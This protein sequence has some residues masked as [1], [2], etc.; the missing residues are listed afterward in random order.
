MPKLISEDG[1]DLLKGILTV[2]PE[3]RLTL[4][5]IKHHK[6]FSVSEEK[7]SE[8]II[9]GIHQI[10]VENAII[11]RLKEF[12]ID[13]EYTKK[14]IEANKHNLSTTTY[15][16]LLQKYIREGGKTSAN[17]SSKLFSPMLIGRNFQNSNDSMN[18][19]A[20]K[21]P[22]NDAYQLN[23]KKSLCI[24]ANRSTHRYSLKIKTKNID[25]KSEP[26]KVENSLFNKNTKFGELKGSNEK[27]KRIN[28]SYDGRMRELVNVKLEEYINN[29]CHNPY[30]I[31][32]S[33]VNQSI[34]LNTTSVLEK[35]DIKI[36]PPQRCNNSLNRSRK[37]APN[38]CNILR[39]QDI[40]QNS[41][42]VKRR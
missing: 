37:L 36:Q 9:V 13:S 11:E 17:I 28:N 24:N 39:F 29:L 5:G 3:K 18:Q 35:T 15:Y 8:G 31:Q 7:L 2:D 22:T 30:E 42:S 38:I 33:H 20:K 14:C 25:F 26:R 41:P 10:P 6:W 21:S 32:R 27:Y 23:E 34:S 40:T 1:K 12:G 19:I 16:L 4:D